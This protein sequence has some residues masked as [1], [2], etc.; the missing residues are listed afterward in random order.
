MWNFD[1][2]SEKFGW[3]TNEDYELKWIIQLS[4]ISLLIYT[5]S[6]LYSAATKRTYALW[7]GPTLRQS[8]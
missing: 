2:I 4:N 1:F 5:V 8:V 7:V 6:F 3:C